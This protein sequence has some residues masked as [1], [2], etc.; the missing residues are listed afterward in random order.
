MGFLRTLQTKGRFC[1][2]AERCTH[3]YAHQN[4]W[5][6]CLRR[7]PVPP[8]PGDSPPRASSPRGPA[9][10]AGGPPGWLPA[11]LAGPFPHAPP[12]SA[13]GLT[14]P[15]PPC[16]AGRHFGKLCRRQTR[17]S[18]LPAAGGGYGMAPRRLPQLGLPDAA[19]DPSRAA[20]GAIAASPRQHR[21]RSAPAPAQ[22]STLLCRSRAHG[23]VFTVR[24]PESQESSGSADA[25]G[26]KADDSGH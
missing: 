18:A 20:L 6:S 11:G 2:Q 9:S 17:S 7:R 24:V 26:A 22:S 5:M 3:F 14:L 21:G 10:S 13:E 25:Q 8:P 23:S 16:W 15:T 4:L 19:Q 12:G 1:G